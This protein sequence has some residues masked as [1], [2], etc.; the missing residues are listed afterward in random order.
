VVVDSFG[1]SICQGGSYFFNGQTI[2]SAGIYRDTTTGTNTC[3]SITI[4][5]L[6]VKNPI[7]DTIDASI[8]QGSSYTF[9]ESSYS[10]AGT[11]TYTT[12]GSNGC[13]STATLFL[14]VLSVITDSLNASICQG[15]S[16]NFNGHNLST[17]GVYTDTLIATGG[18]DSVVTLM[19]VVDTLPHVSWT[20]GSIDTLCTTA[21][22]VALTQGQPTGGVY[23]GTGVSGG[24]FYP[25]SAGVGAHIVTY[26]YQNGFGCRDSASGTFVV[27]LCTGIEGLTADDLILFPN[28]ASD[29][30]MLQ[31][32][33]LVDNHIEMVLKDMTGKSVEVPYQLQSGRVLIGTSNLAQ[34][35]Y[36]VI[37]KLNGIEFSKRFVKE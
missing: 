37:L 27:K 18:C 17:G 10:T 25:D 3:D 26:T 34:G 28:P 20:G 2:T 22:S 23:S 36:M 14:Q 5:N 32:A 4:L 11:Y 13:D 31:S 12:T 30:V 15:S 7:F 8:C 9:G 24:H 35:M 29:L 6:T 1:V 21:S 16:Y 33:Y 19:L